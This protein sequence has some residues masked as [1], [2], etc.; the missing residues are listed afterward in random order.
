M[1][2]K[3]KFC[4]LTN[5]VETTSLWFNS[6]RPETGFKVWKDGMPILL[7]IYEKY[8]IKTTFFFCMDIVKI[9]PDVVKMIIP[10]GHEVASHGYSHDVNEAFD[11]LPFDKQLQHLRLSKKILEDISGQE[12]VSFRAPALR[13]NKFTAMALAEAGY[14][15]DS[16]IPSQR[17]DFFLSFGSV[18]KLKWILAPRKPY[19]TKPDD[20]A[21]K[22]DGSIFEI[23]LSACLFPFMG[24]TLRMMPRVTRIQSQILNYETNLTGKPVVF[25]I[26][27]NEFIDESITPRIITRRSDNYV[28]YLL[29]DIIRS[30]LK[31]KNIGPPAI[32]L[33]MNLIDF[34][35]E[36]Q[37]SFT[38]IKEYSLTLNK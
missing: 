16:S 17:F 15:N 3:Q 28:T 4:L 21:K 31:L 18:K 32:P 8:N 38:T 13:V 5:D 34:Y 20:L 23:P 29:K 33:F 37:Y 22:G 36:Q 7:D 10:Y 14:K 6:L 1:K 19:R 35:R 12:V 2:V 30:N 9:Y 27:P 25:N 24:T 26:H 11:T